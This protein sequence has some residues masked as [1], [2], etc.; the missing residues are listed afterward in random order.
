[1]WEIK[2]IDEVLA[3]DLI[4]KN[5]YS[6]IMPRLTKHILGGYFNGELWGVMTLGWGTRPLH[7]IQVIFPSLKTTDYYE[8]GKLCLVEEAPA[9]SESQFI[10]RCLK[11]A[12][13]N[14]EV[15]LIFSWADGILG[16]PGYV[17]QASNFQYGGY[18]W[19]DLYISDTGE[20]VH[21]RTAQGL[22]NVKQKKTVK[23][24]HRPTKAQLL[25]MGWKHY[26][27]KQF[28]YVYFLGSRGEKKRLLA[29]SPFDW[30][31]P[32]PKDHDLEWK[33]Q[34]LTT[35]DWSS[36]SSI[37]YDPESGNTT[38]RTARKNE[39]KVW[40]YNKAKQFFEL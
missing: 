19:T 8:I 21:P 15:S 40:S 20:K 5:H 4:F 36:I 38:N 27:G 12:K 14:L 37:D 3:L 28:R 39:S 22:M 13:S 30:M 10:S 23:I 2:E 31:Q 24:G 7:T 25:E 18:I 9:N 17:Y 35:G 11:W 33:I 34:N 6:K 1:M 29:E 32:Y 16:K 26:R